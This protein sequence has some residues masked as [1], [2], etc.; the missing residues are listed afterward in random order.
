MATRVKE[1]ESRRDKYD[2]LRWTDGSAWRVKRGVD[3][4]STT[5][6]FQSSLYQRA[7]RHGF[8]VRVSID[9]DVVKFQFTK[10]KKSKPKRQT[11]AT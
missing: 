4:D 2:W 3:F 11:A 1:F 10:L 9:G 7:R 5:E 8:T 6:G